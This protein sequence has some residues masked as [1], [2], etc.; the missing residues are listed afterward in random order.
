MRSVAIN[1]RYF[2]L[3]KLWSSCYYDPKY[4][5]I[6]VVFLESHVQTG[7][8]VGLCCRRAR[9]EDA[10]EQD[11]RS[12]SARLTIRNKERN[13][14]FRKVVDEMKRKAAVHTCAPASFSKAGI[15]RAKKFL[16]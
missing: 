13:S 11:V 4:S 10:A 5:K 6:Q 12:K 7:W 14:V 3:C 9:M 8:M 1:T 16:K 15:Q 2:N